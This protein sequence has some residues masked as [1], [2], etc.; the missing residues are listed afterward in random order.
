MP[1]V[2]DHR[3]HLGPALVVVLAVALAYANALGA[4]F[5]FDD[6]EVI[7]RDPRVQSL[8]AWWDSMPGMRPLLKLSYALNHASGFGVIGFHAVNVLIHGANALLVLWLVRQLA[9]QAGVAPGEAAW[10]ATVTALV[11]ALHPVQTE[12]VTYASGRSA[13]LSAGF[14]LASVALWLRGRDRDDWRLRDL[15]SPALMLAAMAVKES[16]VMVPALLVLWLVADPA[17]PFT[18]RAALRQTGLHGALLVL[19][20][21]VVLALPAYREFVAVSLATR[22][23][24]ENLLAQPQAFGWLAGQLVRFD[25]L[26]ADPVLPVAT[27]LDVS[28]L[29]VLGVVVV[30]VV[31]A[32]SWLGKR[33]LPAVAVLWMLLCLLPTSSLLARLDLV[34]DR[35]WYLAL[36]GPALLVALAL[37]WLRRRW[38]RS[39]SALVAL[40]VLVLATATWQRN[41][42]YHDELRFWQDVAAKS[43]HNARAFNNIGIA[44]ADR[45]DT[46]QAE[47]A[48]RQ[49][50]TLDPGYV[51]AAVNLKL[52]SL[53]VLPA[54]VGVACSPLA[55]GSGR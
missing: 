16:A 46:A 17:R 29:F 18:L 7:V 50:L 36:L 11:F 26:N 38:L 42:V 45:C 52:L 24:V 48:W 27:S 10:L 51:R 31:L 4:A 5:Q 34:N 8:A 3:L 37:H 41:T 43:P 12:A 49:A 1:A 35:H 23:P 33:P 32:L 30:A 21:A 39:G 13:S 20:L 28:S 55:A 40:L 54:G 25:A 14:A 9:G 15:A 22:S 2:A 53:S 44:F 19:A 6:W 47:Q